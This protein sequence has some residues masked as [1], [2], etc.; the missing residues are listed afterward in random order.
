M[1]FKKSRVLF[2]A[3]VE[4]LF[5]LSSLICASFI[6]IIVIFILYRGVKPFVTSEYPRVDFLKFIIGLKW[7]S[8]NEFGALF[9]IIN[10]LISAAFAMI[11]A[12]PIGVL[13]ALFVSRI[14]P[15][16]VSYLIENVVEI[17]ASIPSIIYGIIGSGLISKGIIFI[18]D[19]FGYRSKGGLSLL[20]VALVLTLITLP[21]I[22]IISITAIKSVNNKLIQGSL[23]L[24]ASDVQTNFKIVLLAA[25]SGIFSGV[26]LAFGRA[27]GEATAIS[28]VSGNSLSGITLNPL[29]ITRTLTS[30]M[31]SGINESFGVDYDIRFSLGIV[32]IIIILISNF[33]LNSIKNLIGKDI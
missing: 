25:K 17:L 12:V 22:T 3:V 30:T 32:L 4:R 33:A 31:L 7:I 23:A 21:T 13:T 28:M 24:G 19:I 18:S 20:S 14:A 11:I 29:D 15:K 8:P 10:T 27:L 2:D 26:I 5:M 16:Y 1:K 9:L 6:A